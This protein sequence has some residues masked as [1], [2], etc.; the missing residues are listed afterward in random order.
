MGN[1]RRY[2]AGRGVVPGQAL[3]AGCRRPSRLPSECDELHSRVAAPCPGPTGQGQVC[4]A[5]E[6]G[7]NRGSSSRAR[8]SPVLTSFPFLTPG[9]AVGAGTSW[10][11]G[12]GIC[13][14][15]YDEVV[16]S[17]ALDQSPVC[18]QALCAVNGA[19]RHVVFAR[20][21]A[22][23]GKRRPLTLLGRQATQGPGES[24][25]EGVQGW[26]P[27]PS[28]HATYSSK[29][30]PVTRRGPVTGEWRPTPPS[31]GRLPP[32]EDRALGA[33]GEIIAAAQAVSAEA[34]A[35]PN[36]AAALAPAA[37]RRPRRAGN[38]AGLAGASMI[39][40][41]LA[42]PAS[43]RA[44]ADTGPLATVLTGSAASAA[45]A[46]P[47][48][49][50]DIATLTAETGNVR[51]Q[52]QACRYADLASQLPGLLARLHSACLTLAGDARSSALAL[53]ADAHHVAAG[54]LLKL[55]D[56]GLAY[57]AAE[58]EIGSNARLAPSIDAAGRQGRR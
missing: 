43:G 50:A 14:A 53:S 26:R 6:P 4:G 36:Q 1:Y 23:K 22:G 58:A 19:L 41:V 30:W 49:P 5:R 3:H 44:P 55:D 38:F 16:N 31:D 10:P 20:E 12:C 51:R 21:N 47:G 56:Q 34:S 13:G 32:V 45:G 15:G 39:S 8:S 37:S 24:R 25:T 57:L 33:D 46:G 27:A 52:Y 2:R 42:E 54:L 40:A 48:P 7:V 18:E 35:A 11:G 29:R 9:A 28:P 17:D